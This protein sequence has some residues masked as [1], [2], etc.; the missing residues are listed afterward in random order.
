M[1]RKYR[2]VC[3]IFVV[4]LVINAFIVLNG[5]YYGNNN[6]EYTDV[7]NIN[8]GRR[9]FY[10]C[11]DCCH[12]LLINQLCPLYNDKKFKRLNSAT[13]KETRNK[14]LGQLKILALR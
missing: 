6:L 7:G 10:C 5:S 1:F 3:I 8:T 13:K 12:A 9:D 2:I 14:I 11:Q 4:F